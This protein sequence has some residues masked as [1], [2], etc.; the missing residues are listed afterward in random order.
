MIYLDTSVIVASLSSEPATA[1]VQEWLSGQ[2]PAELAISDWTI[3]EVSSALAMKLRTGQID[4][5]RRAAALA[6]FNR[7]VSESLTV[8]AV[9]S[10]QFR[11][12]ARF[13]DRHA[14]GIRA[15]D[16]LHL[17]IAS[18]Q[19]ATLYTLDRQLAEAGPELGVPTR[20]LD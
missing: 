2:N 5:Q 13:T 18:D 9:T 19:G 3:T 15:A 10:S 1:R 4:V 16:A 8:L 17:A 11:D 14:L 20:L 12:A 6:A 7:L